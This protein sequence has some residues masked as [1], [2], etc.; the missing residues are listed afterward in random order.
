VA[1]LNR[2]TQV[3]NQLPKFFETIRQGQAPSKFNRDF[4]RDIGFKSSN[5]LEFI[6]LL[7]GLGFISDNGAPTPRYKEFLDQTRWKKVL[8]EAI[9]ESYSDIFVMKAKP[10]PTDLPMIAGKYKSTFNIS[11]NQADRAAR[12]FLALLNLADQ[13]TLYSD[14]TSKIDD[15]TDI[16]G[17]RTA[18][19]HPNSFTGYEGC[20]SLQRDL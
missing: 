7:K 4:L 9:K 12:T 2:P 16:R 14:S 8:A 1:L 5:H 3:Y 6:P 18:L 19:R 11:D 15:A 17:I 10:T 13:E 20:G